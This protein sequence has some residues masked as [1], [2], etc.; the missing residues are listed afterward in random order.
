MSFLL[1]V[2]GNNIAYSYILTAAVLFFSATL[3]LFN[4]TKLFGIS[5]TNYIVLIELL[6]M[7]ILISLKNQSLR[8]VSFEIYGLFLVFILYGV[9]ISFYH[10]NLSKSFFQNLFMDLAFLISL[11]F[12]L[13]IYINDK[14]QF[15]SYLKYL[16][17]CL[18]V[19]S[20]I[21]EMIMLSVY[22]VEW[23][24]NLMQKSGLRI[25]PRSFA[26]F[27][28][29]FVSFFLSL[30]VHTKSRIY[31]FATYVAII[32]IYFSMSRM[33]TAA[34][35]LIMLISFFLKGFKNSRLEFLLA[36]VLVGYIYISTN[37]NK[38][39]ISSRYFE[40]ERTEKYINSNEINI[41]GISINSMGRTKLWGEL[42][43]SI[44][45]SLIIG[46]GMGSAEIIKRTPPW[47]KRDKVQPHNDYL[48]I[49]HDFGIV[50]IIL[51]LGQCFI[52]LARLWN[53]YTLNNNIGIK[54]ISLFALYSLLSVGSVALT[55]NPMVYSYIMVPLALIIGLSLRYCEDSI[56][57][58]TT[59]VLKRK[60]WIKYLKLLV[61]TIL[62]VRY[63]K[64]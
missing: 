55:D 45:E 41:G 25:A 37:I 63:E 57:V 12:S 58:S 46:H 62:K 54:K 39:T 29:F 35:L 13:T 19:L 26:I 43:E 53:H 61:K 56:T 20:F 50:G 34:A 2:R 6:F 27:V 52:W 32:M 21:L 15:I 5:L 28:L 30:W 22:G 24:N 60:F 51:F 18:F 42:I 10:V 64:K 16:F 11:Y 33:A 59:N 40:F 31:F 9:G 8:K 1:S 36:L 14:K 48:R 47:D 49:L 7:L 17:Y 38:Y 4:H 3:N 23:G 44:K